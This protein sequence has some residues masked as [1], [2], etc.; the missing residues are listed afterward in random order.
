[1]AEEKVVNVLESGLEFSVRVLFKHPH[2]SLEAITA[3]TGVEPTLFAVLGQP[4]FSPNGVRLAGT[5]PLHIWSYHKVYR[6]RR[7]FQP[8]L[9]ELLNLLEPAKP[10]LSRLYG[11][12]QE[13]GA[14][15]ALILHLQGQRNIGDDIEPALLE[16][17]CA[18][19][20]SLGIEVF[21]DANAAS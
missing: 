17:L 2:V 19:G 6:H 20:L 16:R 11:G 4:R 18:M 12:P 1:M 7:E 8:A 10:L 21:P 15:A 9:M 13:E 5:H 14:Y 3:A